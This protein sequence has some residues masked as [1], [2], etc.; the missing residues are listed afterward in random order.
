MAMSQIEK[1]FG[2]GA[3]MRMGEKPSLDV[4]SIPTGALALD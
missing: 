1:S 3:V 2:K 4:E